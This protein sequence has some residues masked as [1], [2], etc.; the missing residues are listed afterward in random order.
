MFPPAQALVKQDLVNA[1]ALHCDALCLMQ[2]GGQPV[3]RPRGERQPQR[4][5]LGQRGGNHG[6]GLL[7]RVGGRAARPVPVL[8]RLQSFH[9]EAVDALA[10]GLAI[11]TDPGG[12]RRGALAAAGAPDDLGALHVLGRSR[13][14]VSQALDGRELI[15]G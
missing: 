1:A 7:G 2:V 13:V 8:E 11:K 14:G 6:S 5:G 12:N 10:H 9:I 3:E 4:L 15:S